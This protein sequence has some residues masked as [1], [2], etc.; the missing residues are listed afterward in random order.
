[1]PGLRRRSQLRSERQELE[2]KTRRNTAER[3]EEPNP[4]VW[5]LRLKGVAF[6]DIA[7]SQSARRAAPTLSAAV[8]TA[9]AD[10]AKNGRAAGVVLMSGK[11]VVAG[12]GEGIIR[13]GR[14]GRGRRS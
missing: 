8:A 12:M 14:G 9:D 13:H 7:D 6:K 10:I 1:M 5:D 3:A 4:S 2:K 11:Q